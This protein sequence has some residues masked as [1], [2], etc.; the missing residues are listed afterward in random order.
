ML[1]PSVLA[2]WPPEPW[3]TLH[4]LDRRGLGTEQLLLTQLQDQP[5]RFVDLK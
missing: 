2:V 3:L 1:F 5:F 4:T